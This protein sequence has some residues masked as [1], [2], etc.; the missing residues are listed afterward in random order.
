MLS[1]LASGC[2][3]LAVVAYDDFVKMLAEQLKIPTFTSIKDKNFVK[4]VEGSDILVSVHGREIAPPNILKIPP[5]RCINVHPC[6]YRYKGA[7]PIGR[8]LKD[9][10]TKASVGVHYMEEKLDA[11]EVI[12]EE[13]VDVSGRETVA[14]VYNELYPYYATTLLKAL[15]IICGTKK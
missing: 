14:E 11:G 1:L 10:N 6:L 5:K 3:V 15:K 2:D 12:V 8:L 7:D 9:K 4:M 13:F